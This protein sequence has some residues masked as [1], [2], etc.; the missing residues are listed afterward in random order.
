MN[1]V[2]MNN[3]GI[4]ETLNN[5]WLKNKAKNGNIIPLIKALRILTGM[6]LKESK[7]GVEQNCCDVA[8]KLSPKK[9]VEY[10]SKW[11][12]QENINIVIQREQ[13]KMEEQRIKTQA[14]LEER[15]QQRQQDRLAI[16]KEQQDYEARELERQKERDI[17]ET[18]T[19]VSA[20]ECICTHW[21]T[22]GFKSKLSGCNAVLTNFEY[23]VPKRLN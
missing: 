5:E 9:T 3:C 19:I 17:K 22:L 11:M 15:E 2:K 13:T 16:E 10:F 23:E 8:M 6:G 1:Y 21:Q 20:I 4:E 7:D 14:Y 18:Q 12:T